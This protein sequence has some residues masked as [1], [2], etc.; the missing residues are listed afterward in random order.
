MPGKQMR[1][2][3][4]RALPPSQRAG[5]ADGLGQRKRSLMAKAPRW[6]SPLLKRVRKM[7][8]RALRL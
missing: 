3:R 2:S 1:T 8:E 5:R 4:C 6:S 7:A